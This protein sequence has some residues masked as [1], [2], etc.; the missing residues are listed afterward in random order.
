MESREEGVQGL[1]WV[2]PRLRGPGSK[3]RGSEKK[4]GGGV[5]RHEAAGQVEK[6]PTSSEAAFDAPISSRPSF[7]ITL[8]ASHLHCLSRFISSRWGD[9]P[10]HQFEAQTVRFQTPFLRHR[11]TGPSL[12]H[13]H[14]G[15]G[16]LFDPLMGRR[17]ARL[18]SRWVSLE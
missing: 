11:C 14:G 8:C 12:A 17:K 18:C 1:G 2:T 3:E 16:G 4:E 9:E 10:K 7:L 5:S 6:V 15:M 13:T